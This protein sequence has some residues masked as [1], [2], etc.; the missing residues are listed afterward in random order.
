MGIY[1]NDDDDDVIFMGGSDELIPNSK[2]FIL[3]LKYWKYKYVF[4]FFD[5]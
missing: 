2:L 3:S 4:L 1:K 5:K